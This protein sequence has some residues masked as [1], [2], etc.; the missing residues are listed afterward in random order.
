MTQNLCDGQEKTLEELIRI[1]NYPRIRFKRLI[2]SGALDSR[3]RLASTEPPL[4]QGIPPLLSAAQKNAARSLCLSIRA[5]SLYQAFVLEGCTGSGKTE[6]Y[7]EAIEACLRL[8]RQVLILFP[9]IA[10]S[11]M[12][13]AR[14]EKRFGF[15]PTLWHSSLKDSQRKD[16][17]CR[18]MTG[19][20]RLVVGARSALFL[21][22]P[23]LGLIIVD[24]EHDASFKQEDGII[25]NA[26][27][28]AIARAYLGRIPI[29]LVSATPSLETLLNIQEKGFT[30]L[31]LPERYG[32]ARMPEIVLIDL[33]REALAPRA[34]ISPALQGA[35]T[36]T[37]EK[38]EQ[39]LL[40]LNRRG[41][42]PITFCN[43]CGYRFECRFCSVCL[44]EHRRVQERLLC[45]HC[46]FSQ[47]RPSLC[48]GCGSAET[49]VPYGPGVERI[50][51]EAAAL[52]PDARRLILTSDTL[53]TPK[54]LNNLFQQIA[55]KSVDLL[56]ST[57]IMSKGY[58]FPLLTLVG[59]IDGDPLRSSEDLRTSERAYQL[60]YQISG[61]AGRAERPGRV[62]IQ[63]YNPEH[64][65][66]RALTSGNP[67]QFLNLEMQ[68]RKHY[69]MPPFGKLVAIIVSSTDLRKLD[70]TVRALSQSA[71]RDPNVSVFGPIDAPLFRLSKHYRKRFLIKA[72]LAVPIQKIIKTW[73]QSIKVP[74]RTRIAIDIDPYTFS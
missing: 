1:T 17:W 69:R 29:C 59:I 42:A 47:D 30:H 28:M 70:H 46:G 19:E 73:I 24:E 22:F 37:L 64:R 50:D 9:E 36:E 11:S 33:R 57:Q 45:H 65:I 12:M 67:G 49:L 60:L 56:I 27:D 54:N 44:V 32:S 26:R 21:P 68:A 62:L 39:A 71:P 31:S 8:G 14:L 66:M 58:H 63:T 23:N 2:A 25:Y 13:L 51:E 48:P 6:V 43:H 55:A 72:A 16:S 40:F 5:D 53:N 18:I 15:S 4:I 7:C 3:Y 35:I 41:Y 52:F 74:S 10:L 34:W 20:T 38:N 61:R